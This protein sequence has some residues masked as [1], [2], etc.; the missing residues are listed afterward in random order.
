MTHK[1][2]RVVKPQHN[3][4][5]QKSCGRVSYR[6]ELINE[7]V[8]KQAQVSWD[9]VPLKPNKVGLFKKICAKWQNTGYP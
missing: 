8:K 9:K 4:N 2:C 3:Q 1:D 6:Q 5:P 7:N